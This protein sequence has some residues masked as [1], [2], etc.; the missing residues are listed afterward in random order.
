MIPHAPQKVA[1]AVQNLASQ[2][3]TEKVTR[4]FAN[5][6]E[7]KAGIPEHSLVEIDNTTGELK[8]VHSPI[9]D[10]QTKSVDGGTVILQGGKVVGTFGTSKSSEKTDL[11]MADSRPW[12]TLEKYRDTPNDPAYRA[13][14][15]KLSN[16]LY[17]VTDPNDPTRTIR[18]KLPLEGYPKPG[19]AAVPGPV[20]DRPTT[21]IEEGDVGYNALAKRLLPPGSSQGDIVAFADQ[22]AE[23]NPEFPSTN[24]PLG[25][26]IFTGP[27]QTKEQTQS[28]P[29]GSQRKATEVESKSTKFAQRMVDSSNAIDKLYSTGYRPSWTTFKNLEAKIQERKTWTDNLIQEELIP[30]MDLSDQDKMFIRYALDFVSADLRSESG[31]AIKD[32]EIVNGLKRHFEKPTAE[33]SLN[34]EQLSIPV[35]DSARIS[36]INAIKGM[37]NMSGGFYKGPGTETFMSK[38]KVFR[39]VTGDALKNDLIKEFN[40]ER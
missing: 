23:W 21:N 13:A 6:D 39:T 25:Q 35:L 29:V 31:A 5:A 33:M 14:Y 36:R 28:T 3:S 12:A 18:V 38:D 15:G 17:D 9:S 32:S 16:R 30:G 40:L 8:I 11:E 20:T 10:F 19:E 27:P 4:R 7:I 22:L 26:K 2:A 24:L 37:I 34:N 1:A